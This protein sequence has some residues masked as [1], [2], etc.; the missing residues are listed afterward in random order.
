[1]IEIMVVCGFGVIV[2]NFKVPVL[3][4]PPRTIN[5]GYLGKIA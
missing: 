2:G 5:G 1:M 4:N 3:A